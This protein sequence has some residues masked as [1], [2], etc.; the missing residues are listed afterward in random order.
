M[1]TLTLNHFILDCS[2][3]LA[4]NPDRIQKMINVLTWEAKKYRNDHF[5]DPEIVTTEI[6]DENLVTVTAY[7]PFRQPQECNV[8]DLW[9]PSHGMVPVPEF[10]W[11]EPAT[12]EPWRHV[13]IR[14][15]LTPI[16][17]ATRQYYTRI[18]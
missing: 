5:L 11:R 14:F 13:E 12:S 8:G 3:A 15:T 6:E 10:T 4:S 2:T 9:S 7:I 1:P 17:G 16:H 18:S